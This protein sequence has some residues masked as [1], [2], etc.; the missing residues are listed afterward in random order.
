MDNL[1]T[2]S[3]LSQQPKLNQRILRLHN[4]INRHIHPNTPYSVHSGND[5]PTLHHKEKKKILKEVKMKEGNL[6]GILV[7][8]VG[9]ISALAVGSGMIDGT[10][11]IPAIPTIITIVAGWVVVVGAILSLILAVFSK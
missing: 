8:I 10:L 5:I 6:V 1:F 3:R 11:M 4:I 7:W 9:V 2:E